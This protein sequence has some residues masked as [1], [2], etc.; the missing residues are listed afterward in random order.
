M[1]SAVI[2]SALAATISAIAC[3]TEA[4]SA[5]CRKRSSTEYPVSPSSGKTA[6]ATPSSWQAW[7]CSMTSAA[8]A[9]G[10]ARCTGT[11]HAA[12]RAKPWA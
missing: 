4:S 12:M 3:S 5:S 11:V 2:R 1:T 7:A 8:L 6:T 9:A 10:S